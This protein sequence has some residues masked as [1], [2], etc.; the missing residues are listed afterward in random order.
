FDKEKNEWQKR[1]LDEAT[2]AQIYALIE[3]DKSLIDIPSV[4]V[5][6]PSKITLFVRTESPS[7]WQ[8]EVKTF[9]T[10][11]FLADD[12]Y[13]VELH[14]DN[15]GTNFAYF[16]HPDIRQTVFKIINP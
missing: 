6:N 14:E 8:K 11:E 10:I 3:G 2:Y 4:K 13:R 9:Q 1:N 12:Y 5:E 16:N 15:P 7:E